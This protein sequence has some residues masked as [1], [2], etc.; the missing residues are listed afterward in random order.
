MAAGMQEGSRSV[1]EIS[2][3]DVPVAEIE[4]TVGPRPSDRLVE[5]VRRHGVVVPV[6]LRE[7]VSDEGE[8][9]YAVVDGNRR[10]ASAREAEVET[11]PARV[12]G[13]ASEVDAAQVTLLTNSFRTGNYVTELWALRALER[14]GID[15]RQLPQV[16]GMSSST[17][18]TR[19]TLSRLERRL[20]VGLAEGKIGPTVATAAAKL[21]PSTQHALG[22]EFVRT[23]R[24]AKAMVDA[25]ARQ[26][27]AGEDTQEVADEVALPDDIRS[28]LAALVR[29]VIE[30]G[31]EEETWLDA[32]RTAYRDAAQDG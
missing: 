15:R 17:I 28:A 25:A 18:Q 2:S 20:F 8:L 24:L 16:T 5:S 10:V 23:G 3:R 14:A 6:I 29:T 7:V 22:D 9:A 30:R 12:L 32:A 11:V 21:G 1:V 19:E 27:A 31:V 4:Q 26:E 13:E